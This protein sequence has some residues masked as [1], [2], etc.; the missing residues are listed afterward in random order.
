MLLTESTFLFLFLPAFI[1][2][3]VAVTGA[4]T[5]DWM[6]GMVPL[7]ALN[8]FLLLG[9]VVYFAL[10]SPP[11]AGLLVVAAVFT[12]GVSLRVA[13]AGAGR[14]IWL[15]CGLLGL[16]SLFVGVRWLNATAQNAGVLALPL[17]GTPGTRGIVAIVV[18]FFVLS[19][20][21]HVL[22]AYR[23]RSVEQDPVR[24]L[25]SV[26]LFP[27]LLAGPIVKRSEMHDQL[28][29]RVVSVANFAYGMRRFLIGLYK[30]VAI[31]DIL[32]QVADTIFAL[33]PQQ[34]AAARAWLGVVC[35]GLQLYFAVSAYSDMA[36]GLGRMFGFRLS[37]NFKW[38]Y[39]TRSLHEF[40]GSWF[41]TLGQW[42]RDYLRLPLGG[43]PI[44][45][46]L[47][48]FPVAGAWYGA[49][50]PMLVWALYHAAFILLERA[51]LAR[52]LRRLPDPLPYVYVAVVVLVGWPLFRSDTIPAALQYLWSMA[53]R[54][55][56]VAS[57]YYLNRFLTT[58]VWIALICGLVGAAPLVRAIGRWRV[59]IDGG[60]TALAVMTFAVLVYIWRMGV[61]LVTTPLK[62]HQPS[63]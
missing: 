49:R 62:P 29:R 59:A 24:A 26:L 57:A 39:V 18:S 2:L 47:C 63:A 50:W 3:H 31:A 20:S 30:K 1:V 32:G 19:A 22:D 33:P 21:A 5:P 28:A 25:L 41:M 52:L 58:E 54:N 56:P 11:L 17:S 34:V 4:A 12:Y 46:T 55:V 45:L 13:R 27:F 6:R 43:G 35:F 44:L 14:A 36:L 42:L 8:V 60:T 23:T 37:E 53:G 61:R 48:A 9:S 40:W 51:G 16:S 7:K 38:P 10:L 15:A